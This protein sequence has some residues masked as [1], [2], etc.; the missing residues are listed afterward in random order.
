MRWVIALLFALLSSQVFAQA[1]GVQFSNV[2]CGP[3]GLSGVTYVSTAGRSVTC[4]TDSTG[5]ALVLQVSTL[6]PD[7]PIEGGEQI[8]LDIGAAMLLVM[9]AAWCV[10]AVRRLIESGGEG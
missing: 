7:L 9:A 4:G 3:S 1:S 5:A 8:G 10:R 6:S 2:V